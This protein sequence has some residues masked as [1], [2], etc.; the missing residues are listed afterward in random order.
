[1]TTVKK[2]A[3]RGLVAVVIMLA[4]IL[5]S[6][7]LADAQAPI[8]PIQCGNDIDAT[9]NN[10]NLSS[11]PQRFELGA[12]CIFTA[13]APVQP[14]NGDEVVC[15]VAPDFAPRGPAF[16]PTAYCTIKGSSTLAQ[17][18]K[19][20]GTV[21]L[22]GLNIEG[23]DFKGSSGTGVGISEGSMSDQSMSYGIVVRNN[24]AAGIT[25]GRGVHRRIELTSNTTNTNALGFIG[26]GI[27]CVHECNV[28]YSYV[29]ETQGNGIW[30]DSGCDDASGALF[31]AFHVNMNLVVNNE[32]GGVRYENVGSASSSSPGEAIIENNEVHG[33]VVKATSRGGID[34]RDAENATV[35]G[36]RFGA[37]TI[38]STTPPL[39]VNYQRNWSNIGIRASNSGKS[40]RGRLANI[41]VERNTMNGEAIKSCGGVV[42]CP[43]N[44]P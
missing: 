37:V 26:S 24:E 40:G 30:C 28:E 15:A 31:S 17:V 6:Y 39:S 29:H 8:V 27:K 22:E 9:I 25:N 4:L 35:R 2:A 23:G 32:R 38:T 1:L 10:P 34:I 12:G 33:N 18:L 13:S 21:Y 44:T 42:V 14:K 19:P 36:N 5:A 7:S 20:Q 41:L 3:Q 16:D 11:T 43:I